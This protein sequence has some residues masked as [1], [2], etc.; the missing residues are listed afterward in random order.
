MLVLKKK[1]IVPKQ[2]FFVGTKTNFL[3]WKYSFLSETIQKFK[4]FLLKSL[5]Y[6]LQFV[7]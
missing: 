4:W 3:V 6:I 2:L 7:S 5:I 1:K